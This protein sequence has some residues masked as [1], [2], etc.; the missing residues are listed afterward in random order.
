ALQVEGEVRESDVGSDPNGTSTYSVWMP[1]TD[2]FLDPANPEKG[3]KTWEQVLS[4]HGLPEAWGSRTRI[5]HAN[6]PLGTHFECEVGVSKPMDAET[7]DGGIEHTVGG[8][9]ELHF[10]G[11]AFDRS[12]IVFDVEDEQRGNEAVARTQ[13]RRPLR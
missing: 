5:V 12:W 2:L 4:E 9:I 6:I 8:G 10:E 13:R 3:T 11:T 1:K 7:A